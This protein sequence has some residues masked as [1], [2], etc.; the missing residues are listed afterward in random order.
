MTNS[1]HSGASESLMPSRCADSSSV[2][3]PQRTKARSIVEDENSKIEAVL[4]DQQKQKFEA[5]QQHMRH[6]GNG[7]PPPAGAP[8]P[9]N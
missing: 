3:Q 6:G 9:Q 4:N 2:W 7:G 8:Q 1:C 5:M